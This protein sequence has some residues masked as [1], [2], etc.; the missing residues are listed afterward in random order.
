MSE[1]PELLERFR[2]GP[3]LLAALLT[4]AAGREF[5]F[6]PAPGKWSIR[7]IMAHLVDSEMMGASRFRQAI[8]EDNPSFPAWDQDAWAERLDYARRKPSECMETFRRVRRETYE[9]LE[10]MQPDIYARTCVHPRR[11]PLKLGGLLQLYTEHAEKHA[12]Q[13]Q[14]LREAYRQAKNAG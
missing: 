9:L 8:A 6:A 12:K 13:I 2:R 3:E 1:I 10:P 4:G 5:D 14:A 7:Q 11:G